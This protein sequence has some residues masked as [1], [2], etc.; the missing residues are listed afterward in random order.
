MFLCLI[1]TGDFNA[2]L[3]RLWQNDITNSTSQE[4][5]SHISAEN[6]Q[7]IDKRKHVENNYVMHR[8]FILQKPKDTFKITQLMFKSLI[9]VT[10]ILSL[11]RLHPCTTP[12]IICL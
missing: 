10:I 6:K 9:N 8:S 3:L 12:C 7:I 4:I 1:V 11:G 2:R 5:D